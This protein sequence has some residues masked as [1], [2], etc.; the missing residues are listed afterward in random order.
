MNTLRNALLKETATILFVEDTF[1][2]P[3]RFKSG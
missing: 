1:P 3:V 2:I